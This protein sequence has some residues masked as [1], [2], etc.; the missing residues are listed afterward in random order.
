MVAEAQQRLVRCRVVRAQRQE[1]RD[2]IGCGLGDERPGQID[3]VAIAGREMTQD[4]ADGFFEYV[5]SQ[6]RRPRADARDRSLPRLGAHGLIECSGIAFDVVIATRK[7]P[8]TGLEAHEVY[9]G[10]ARSRIDGG[11]PLDAAPEIVGEEPGPPT[12][13]ERRELSESCRS[14]GAYGG[15]G[16]ESDDRGGSIAHDGRRLVRREPTQ[17]IV[18]TEAAARAH[19]PTLDA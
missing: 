10:N 19:R 13:P 5:A 16:S 12:V 11:Y 15:R 1:E 3:L 18:D 4:R 2:G 8:N 6:A 14:R 7:K 17:K 9:V